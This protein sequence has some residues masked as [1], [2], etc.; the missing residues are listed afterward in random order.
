[1]KTGIVLSGGGIRGI[2]HF[3]VLK[4]LQEKDIKISMITGTSAG[5]IAGALFANGIDPYEALQ[6]FQETRLLRFIRPAFKSPALLNLEHA[7]TLF[8]AY[9]PHDSFEALKIPLVITATDFNE[10]KLVYFSEGELIR[11]VLASSCI[12]GVFSPIMME[13]K[14]FVDGGVLNNFPIEPLLNQCDI[15]IGSSCNHLPVVNKFRNM[16]HVIERA[17]ILSINHDMEEKRKCIDVL[18]EPKGLGETS[19]FDVKKAEEIFWIAYEETL[20]Q[21]KNIK[22]I[23]EI[24]K[25]GKA[26]L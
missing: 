5:A 18:I 20:N 7:A 10:G 21:I 16:K 17:A 1:M 19:I 11:R 23:L 22:E 13:G 26:L 8:K 12:P 4:A 25:K 3:G 15:I 6:I 2:A 14:L 24:K 9:L